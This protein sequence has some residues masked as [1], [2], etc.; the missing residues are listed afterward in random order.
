VTPPL[1]SILVVCKNAARTIERCLASLLAQDHPRLHIVV[2]DGASS[3]GTLG[4][5]RSYGDRLDVV[6]AP[7]R[8]QNEAFLRGIA[9]CRGDVVGF[10]WADE[11]LSPGAVSRAV[12]L[13]GERPELGA[14]YGDVIFT[15][16]D[17]VSDRVVPY[18][19]WSFERVFT[20]EFIPP[21]C[22]SF[23]RR[24]ALDASFF[25]LAP[26]GEDCTEY[27]LW[28]SVGSRYP[29][30][31]LPQPLARYARHGGQLSAQVPRMVAYV[32]QLVETIER[33]A[34]ADGMPPV[35]PALRERAITNVHL[36][37]AQWLHEACDARDEALAQLAAALRHDPEPA[38]LATVA[39]NAIRHSLARR[40]PDAA[41]TWLDTLEHGGIRILG[42]AY[43]RSLAR[44]QCG[45]ATAAHAAAAVLG[46]EQLDGFWRIVPDV[47]RAF[48]AGTP[49]R[50]PEAIAI[51][52]RVAA[53]RSDFWFPLSLVLGELALYD[54]AALAVAQH[55][56]AFPG[57]EQ[58]RLWA[59][60]LEVIRC[61]R[62]EASRRR[63]ASARGRAECLSTDEAMHVADS[64]WRLVSEPDCAARLP[65]AA[66]T[67]LGQMV[68]TLHATA[69]DGGMVTLADALARLEPKLA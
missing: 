17:G 25:P 23:F 50:V 28:A 10:C 33:L 12:R 59:L 67:V 8:D 1:V 52:E 40:Q 14:V 29:I 39:W 48:G 36:W 37:A 4:I 7:D 46:A 54:R 24:A 64:V 43:A 31:R 22:A 27:L 30:A 63:L 20:Y 53:Q 45:D 35:V 69:V 55:R 61:A 68:A 57:D 18:P 11:S 9:R 2:Q 26:L 62:E 60:Q 65:A 41:D 6:S 32:P 15:D 66:R 51:L 5:L 13:L 47:L 58:G 16:L 3:D 56:R 21:V 42:H 49:E 44:L 38:W 19:E 34:S